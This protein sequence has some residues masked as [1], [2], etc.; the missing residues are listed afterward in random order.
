M[1]DRLNIKLVGAVIGAV[2]LVAGGVWFWT[3][4]RVLPAEFVETLNSSA[5]RLTTVRLSNDGKQLVAGSSTGDVVVWDWPARKS[6]TLEPASTQPI[7]ALA[8]SD[9]GLLIATGLHGQLRAWQL[10]E[11]QSVKLES[12]E[13]AVTA[14]TY[15]HHDDERAVLLGLADGRIATLAGK[16]LSLHKSGH[17]GVK[18]MLL[19]KEQTV[20]V[21]V[22]TE[23]K[24]VWYDLK[25]ARPLTTVNAHQ[26]EI[27]ALL[28]NS[29]QTQL[30]TADWNG[31]LC[32]W[33]V[34][35]R[36]RVWEAQQPDAVSGLCWLGDR[37]VS[38]SWDGQV[39]V[40]SLKTETPAI[41]QTIDTGRPIFS[42]TVL[43]QEGLVATVSA[44]RAV[45]FWKLQ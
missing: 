28:M 41:E 43:P 40:W 19:T 1:W 13:V 37:L 16:K 33:D 17:R 36:K 22:G 45:E 20:L 18:G 5:Q 25:A 31:R 34:A 21:S 8:E 9:D 15:R 23:G 26:T 29:E 35:T 2:L 32:G 39:R 27:S 42:L 6:T 3:A 14:I 38:G 44:S 30:V 7:V 4:R 10:P 24:L 12:P 11:V